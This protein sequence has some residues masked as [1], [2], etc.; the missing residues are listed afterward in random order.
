MCRRWKNRERGRE[1]G[2]LAD[3]AN[4]PDGRGMGPKHRKTKRRCVVIE[5]LR[6]YCVWY[7]IQST[8][9]STVVLCPGEIPDRTGVEGKE[10]MSFVQESVPDMARHGRN[11]LRRDEGGE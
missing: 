11:P 5:D 10:S 4:G 1:G 6:Y 9:S 3:P 7:I 2:E 8:P